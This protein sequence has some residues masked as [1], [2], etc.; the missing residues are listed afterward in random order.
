MIYALND[1]ETIVVADLVDDPV[2]TPTGGVEAGEFALEGAA[3]SMGVL[4]QR[5]EHELHDRD[6]DVLGKLRQLPFGGP[7]DPQRERARVGHG[8]RYLARS[9]SPVRKSPAS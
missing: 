1:N 7:G 6:G 3:D 4:D 2:R 5:T 8:L 9:S